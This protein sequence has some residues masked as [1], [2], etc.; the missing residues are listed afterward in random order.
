MVSLFELRNYFFL[1]H[2]TTGKKARKQLLDITAYR[3]RLFSPDF[4]R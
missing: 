3:A 2:I 4:T 1:G